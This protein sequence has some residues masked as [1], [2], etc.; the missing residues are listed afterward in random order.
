MMRF[1]LNVP[2]PLL[3]GGL[4]LGIYRPPDVIHLIISSQ[5]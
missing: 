5:L 1:V 4:G 2:R 3:Q